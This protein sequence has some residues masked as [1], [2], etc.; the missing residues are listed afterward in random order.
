MGQCSALGLMVVLVLLSGC[1]TGGQ[2]ERVAMRQLSQTEIVQGVPCSGHVILHENGRLAQCVLADT[3]TL[4]GNL[5]P[6]G[7]TVS[8]KPEGVLE[9]CF[10]PCDAPIQGLLCRGAGNNFM[11]SFHPSGKLR[12]AWLAQTE[13]IQEVPCASAGILSEIL[14]AR[15]G[16]WFHE[17]GSLARCKAARDFT[18]QGREFEEGDHV[19]LDLEG[20]LSQGE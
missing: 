2:D 10:L 11:N 17:N 12:L 20:N 4:S 8:F 19:N 7:T 5:L 18:I 3:S 16:V 14:G 6:K 9:W 15:A 1:S 13:E